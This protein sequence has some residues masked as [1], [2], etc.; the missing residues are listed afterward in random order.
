MFRVTP[1]VFA[2]SLLAACV[3]DPYAAP[4]QPVDP[5]ASDV[6]ERSEDNRYTV[7]YRG[8][9]NTSTSRVYDLALL[10][11]ATITLQKEGTWFEILTDYA[12]A[13][14]ERETVFQQNPLGRSIEQTADCGVLGCTTSARPEPGY[15][16]LE[17]QSETRA[18]LTQ[19]FEIL[20][21]YDAYNPSTAN[22]YDAVALSDQ[23]RARYA[24]EQQ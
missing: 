15:P 4:L 16:D 7:V 8:S 18:F 6:S 19:K 20:V 1:I 14:T 17:G 5:S 13:E 21:H 3:S 11:A 23:I 2:V 24:A 12:R 10:R 22:A 9:P